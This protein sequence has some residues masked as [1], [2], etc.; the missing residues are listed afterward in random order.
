MKIGTA[1][2]TK[3]YELAAQMG[4]DYVEF[5]GV[6]LCKLTEEEVAAL[7]ERVK[8]TGLRVLGMN[9]YCDDSVVVANDGFSE[10]V[11]RAYAK[12]MADI[13]ARL[14][15]KD[16]GIGAPKARML[17][18]G[19]PMEK[20]DAHAKRFLEITN[21]EMKARGVGLLFEAVHK[22]YCDYCNYSEHCKA[23]VE[24]IG[25]DNLWMVLDFYNMDVMGEDLLHFD[26]YMPWVRHFH[27][28]HRGP[29]NDR[30]YI[31]PEDEPFLKGLKESF[32]R[33]GYDG[34]ITIEADARY[35][36]EYGKEGLSIMQKWMNG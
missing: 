14:G 25:D 11:T 18:E 3:Y 8:K 13:A 9:S 21:E 27:I 1:I 17:P 10:E 7:E 6:E 4:Y 19:Y 32:A 12:K 24:A 36:E 34:T 15:M 31:L 33:V 30:Q 22:D 20:A 29:N 2:P 5:P 28:N 23:M 35:F 16:I 26:Q